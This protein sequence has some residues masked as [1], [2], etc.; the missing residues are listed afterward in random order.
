M[1]IYE[2]T[3]LFI[4][5]EPL[6]AL[7]SKILETIVN[8]KKL[9]FQKNYNTFKSLIDLDVGE[10]FASENEEIVKYCII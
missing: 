2:K 1:F 8:I 6:C 9:N 10:K 7:F 3:Y 5:F 4:A